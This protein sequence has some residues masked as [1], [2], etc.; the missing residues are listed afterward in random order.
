ML[1]EP[2]DDFEKILDDPARKEDFL[3]GLGELDE[4]LKPLL[5]IIKESG[6]ITEKDLNLIIY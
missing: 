4:K 1:V 6:W 5:E 3:K 2:I